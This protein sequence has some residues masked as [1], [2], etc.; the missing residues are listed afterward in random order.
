[1]YKLKIP[2]SMLRSAFTKD[3]SPG[4]NERTGGHQTARCR[5][6]R[7]SVTDLSKDEIVLAASFVEVYSSS[8]FQKVFVFY[9]LYEDIYSKMSC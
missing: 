8:G 3:E 7:T 2:I 4:R 1:M 9:A 5:P 6:P